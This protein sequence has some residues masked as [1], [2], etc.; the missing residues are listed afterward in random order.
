VNLLSGNDLKSLEQLDQKLWTALSCPMHELEIDSG[1]L[2]LIDSDGD[3]R[4]RV[5]E[6][7]D[8]GKGLVS[9]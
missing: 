8:A 7:I 1:T 5:P 2:K 4:I 3:Q 6:V 9:V